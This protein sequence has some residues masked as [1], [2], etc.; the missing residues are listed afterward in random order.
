M[1][2]GLPTAVCFIRNLIPLST[3]VVV[4]EEVEDEQQQQ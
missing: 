4:K 2:D 1:I 3:V